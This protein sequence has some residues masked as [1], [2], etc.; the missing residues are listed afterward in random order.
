MTCAAGIVSVH[1]ECANYPN[2]PGTF[3]LNADAESILLRYQ[4]HLDGR[5]PLPSMA[6]FCLTVLEAKVAGRNR[7]LRAAAEYRIDRAVVRKMAELSTN[8]G[9]LVNAR[10][11]TAV[12][13][14]TGQEGAWLEAVVKMLIWRL[15]D[16]RT[17][18]ALPLITMSDLPTL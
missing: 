16:T 10:K 8:H 1:V 12:K 3:R 9:D 17:L 13:P 11:A 18:S 7:K 14:L 15:G 4:A 6:Y 5:E 2:P